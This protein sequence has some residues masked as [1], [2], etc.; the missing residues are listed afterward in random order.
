MNPMKNKHYLARFIAI[1][2]MSASMLAALQHDHDDDDDDDDYLGNKVSVQETTTKSFPLTGAGARSIEVDN[3]FGSIEVE[4][5]SANSIELVANKTIRAS[6]QAEL[7]RAKREVS[8]DMTQEQNAVRLYVNGPWRCNNDCNCKCVRN[9]RHYVVKYDFKL[10]VPQRMNLKL[11]TVNMGSV[12]VRGVRGDYDV[13]NV[14]GTIDMDEIG[15]SGKVHTVN[16]RVRVTFVENPSADSE[17]KTINGNVDLYFAP[18][19]A[20][21][22]RFKTM[23]GEIYSDFDMT[24]VPLQPAKAERK[25]SR[26]VYRSDR[27]TAARVGNGGPEIKLEN[28]NGDLR[29]LARANN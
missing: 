11:S 3:V 14:N 18:K 22:F 28:L 21:D 8:L 24:Q 16:G 25:G 5:T 6:S 7:E 23:Q 10:K 9:D 15:G 2:L 4:G 27:Y 20:A 12:R 19:L 26:F 17:F 29:V 1:L 13:H